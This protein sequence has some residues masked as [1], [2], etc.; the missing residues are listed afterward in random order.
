MFFSIL[1]FVS[2]LNCESDFHESF[3]KWIPVGACLALLDPVRR[4]WFRIFRLPTMV[5]IG[6][7]KSYT[8]SESG[9]NLESFYDVYRYWLASRWWLLLNRIEIPGIYFTA[10]TFIHFLQCYRIL[11]RLAPPP[12][13]SGALCIGE[14]PHSFQHRRRYTFQ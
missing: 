2:F 12:W 9:S 14:T 5:V 3:F 6:L 7:R 13:F 8:K 10:S 4:N 11:F 1:F